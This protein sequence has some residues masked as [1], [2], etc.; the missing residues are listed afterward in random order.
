MPMERF[1]DLLRQKGVKATF[2]LVG[3]EARQ[4]PALVQRIADN[5]ESSGKAKPAAK[6]AVLSLVRDLAAGVRRA[7][8]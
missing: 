4:Y 7:R 8:N 1:L 3:T 5:L 2:C 6:D